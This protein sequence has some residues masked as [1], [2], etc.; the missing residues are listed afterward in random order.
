MFPVYYLKWI[1]FIYYYTYV[2]S[3]VKIY[4]NNVMVYI[5]TYYIF[6]KLLFNFFLHRFSSIVVLILIVKFFNQNHFKLY[7][8]I[9]KLLFI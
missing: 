2:F 4:L 1:I 3:G 9:K 5:I 7:I 6:F 8:S